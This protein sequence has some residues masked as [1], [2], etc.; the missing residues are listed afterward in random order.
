VSVTREDG[1]VLL[2][3]RD[4]DSRWVPPGGVLELAETPQQACAREV[5]E[6]TGYRVEVG[7]LTGVYKNMKLGVVSLAF[8]CVLV[9]ALSQADTAMSYDRRCAPSLGLV[10]NEVAAEVSRSRPGAATPFMRHLVPVQCDPQARQPARL[11][12]RRFR[13][14]PS[15]W[16]L[17]QPGWPPH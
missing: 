14:Q 4:D 9:E 10:A 15:R 3:K 6:E 11:V 8:R 16:V 13:G 12:W 1:R 17:A 5:L 7:S 2:I